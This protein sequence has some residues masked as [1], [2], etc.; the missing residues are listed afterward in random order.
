MDIVNPNYL[1]YMEQIQKNRKDIENLYNQELSDITQLNFKENDE[2]GLQYANG[3]AIF[4]GKSTIIRDAN[5]E[6]LEANSKVELKISS[7]DNDIV[8]NAGVDNS[9]LEINLDNET[10]NNISRALKTPLSAPT[11]REFVAIDTNNLQVMIPESE[12]ID[13]IEKREIIHS[14]NAI[15]IQDSELT[16]LDEYINLF[17]Q[18]KDSNYLCGIGNQEVSKFKDLVGTPSGF[19]NYASCC[20][21]R[22]CV[23]LASGSFKCYELFAFNDF[24]NNVAKGYIYINASSVAVF[25]GWTIRG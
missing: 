11:E 4:Q 18:S 23:G 1:N 24:G 2:N 16:T 21:K 12:I 20:I 13:N 8:I 17:E 10:K 6:N 19:G 5:S 22:Y 7:G 15:S 14:R 25:T 9:T 3:K